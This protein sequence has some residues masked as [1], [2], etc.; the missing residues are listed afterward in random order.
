METISDLISA[1][2][3]KY[4]SHLKADNETTNL[5]FSIL[6]VTMASM[7]KT[8]SIAL[9]KHNITKAKSSSIDLIKSDSIIARILKDKRKHNDKTIDFSVYIYDMFAAQDNLSTITKGIT[10]IINGS[11][12]WFFKQILISAS[13]GKLTKA[14]VIKKINNLYSNELVLLILKCNEEVSNNFHGDLSDRPI[15]TINATN[16]TESCE[17]TKADH[18]LDTIGKQLFDEHLS[19]QSLGGDDLDTV[20]EQLFDEHLSLQSLA[21]TA[22][23]EGSICTIN[24]SDELNKLLNTKLT[25]ESVTIESEALKENINDKLS[26]NNSKIPLV[27][28]AYIATNKLN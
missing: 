20:G 27:E 25:I 8:I 2:V 1:E 21:K 24:A 16:I 17:L 23:T 14:G 5:V 10:E 15:D 18:E 12:N 4:L 7:V 3:K 22:K 13:G 11:T 26:I 28:A 9:E 19:L 6:K